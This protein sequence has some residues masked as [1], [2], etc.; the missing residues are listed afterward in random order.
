M[1]RQSMLGMIEVVF[2]KFE[3]VHRS[4]EGGALNITQLAL[5]SLLRLRAHHTS[6]GGSIE[7]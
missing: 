1:L 6:K 7:L 2:V 4:S 3:Y 5:S